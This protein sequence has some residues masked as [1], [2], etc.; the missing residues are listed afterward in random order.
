MAKEP[1]TAI[2]DKVAEI[3][4]E[5]IFPE[6]HVLHGQSELCRKAAVAAINFLAGV[7]DEEK[8]PDAPE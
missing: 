2:T 6:E 4:E 1:D 7:Y 8:P 3:I 5:T